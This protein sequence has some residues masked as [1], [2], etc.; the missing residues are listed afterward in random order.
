MNVRELAKMCYRFSLAL[1]SWRVRNMGNIILAMDIEKF[2]EEWV[3]AHLGHGL[4]VVDYSRPFKRGDV[5]NVLSRERGK[6]LENVLVMDESLCE[7]NGVTYV[8]VTGEPG[9]SIEEA[10]RRCLLLDFEYTRIVL[11]RA[12]DEEGGKP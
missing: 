12:V 11:V 2:C 5:V 3:E 10:N 6:V 4:T 8:T 7:F 1:A 9:M